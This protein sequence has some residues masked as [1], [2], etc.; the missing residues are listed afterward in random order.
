MEQILLCV[1]PRLWE[2]QLV[3]P[4]GIRVRLLCRLWA[5]RQYRPL[6]QACVGEEYSA[7]SF[8]V[9]SHGSWGLL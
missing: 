7:F 4:E 6:G 8:V 2:Q 9:V 1:L 5:P 3:V